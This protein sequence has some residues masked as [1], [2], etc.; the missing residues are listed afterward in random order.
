MNDRACKGLSSKNYKEEILSEDC[1]DDDIH[2]RSKTLDKDYQPQ[3]KRRRKKFKRKS[4]SA[5]Y[6]VA[7]GEAYESVSSGVSDDD[8][9][10]EKYCLYRWVHELKELDGNETCK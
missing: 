7:G 1:S 10:K 9:E 2:S 8:T 6:G 3:P 4:M 5:K